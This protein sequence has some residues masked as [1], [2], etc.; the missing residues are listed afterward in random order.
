MNVPL[1]A[2]KEKFSVFGIHQEPIVLNRVALKITTWRPDEEPNPPGAGG[3]TFRP[4][5]SRQ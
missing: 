3:V 4:G 2:I 1:E 5:S